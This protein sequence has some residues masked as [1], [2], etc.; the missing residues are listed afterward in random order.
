MVFSLPNPTPAVTSD[1][2]KVFFMFLNQWDPADSP[3]HPTPFYFTSLHLLYPY[4]PEFL[5]IDL[6]PSHTDLFVSTSTQ[7]HTLTSLC[8]LIAD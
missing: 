1:L 7:R 4:P 2:K 3:V 8:Y 5:F 6:P